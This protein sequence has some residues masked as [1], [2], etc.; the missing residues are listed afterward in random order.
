[1]AAP[2]TRRCARCGPLPKRY[3]APAWPTAALHSR[4]AL[5]ARPSGGGGAVGRRPIHHVAHQRR[6]TRYATV[7]ATWRCT[8]ISPA[9]HDGPISVV[10]TR[11]AAEPPWK[12]VPSFRPLPGVRMTR[13][14]CF[15]PH[16]APRRPGTRAT[17]GSSASIRS[18]YA[19]PRRSGRVRAAGRRS[20]PATSPPAWCRSSQLLTAMWRKVTGALL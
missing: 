19:D 2:V 10:E 17:P 13:P 4:D 7:P 3:A 5:G 11:H 15:G 18:R 9:R 8:R 6:D 20:G 16:P 14:A 12:H 1:M